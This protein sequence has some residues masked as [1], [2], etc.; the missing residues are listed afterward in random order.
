MI[1]IVGLL[2]PQ[3]KTSTGKKLSLHRQL[4]ERLSNA[5]LSGRLPSNTVLTPSRTFAVQLGVSRNTVVL[6]YEQLAAE[7]Y[8]IADQHGTRVAELRLH[9]SSLNQSAML[10]ETKLAERWNDDKAIIQ[11]QPRGTTGLLAP[12]VP[13]LK[14]F[15]L[16]KW[17]RTLERAVK[18]LHPFALVTKDPLGEFSLRQAIATHL[19]IARGVQCE[20]EQIVITEGAQ[21][22]LTLCARLLANPNDTVWVEDPCYSGAKSAFSDEQLSIIPIPVDNEGLAATT[23]HWFNQRPKL[24]FTS[25]A[26]QYPTGAVLSVARRLALIEAAKNVGTWIIE[27]D[28]D[29]DFRHTGTPISSMQGLAEHSPVIYIGSFSKTMF[30][31]IRIGFMVVPKTLVSQVTR[32]VPQI[33]QV[34]NQLQQIALAEFMTS[35]EFG[36]HLGRMRRIYRERQKILKTELTRY[37]P[38]DWVL[39]G[40][41]GMH[42]T[43]RLPSGVD[44]R[45]VAQ[46]ALSQGIS[47]DPLSSFYEQPTA[48]NCGLV[49]GYGNTPRARIPSAVGIL[50]EIIKRENDSWFGLSACAIDK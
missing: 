39:G 36:R 33:L 2:D 7:G 3:A 26:H 30:P 28:Y 13:S 37:F 42:L 1:D 48:N 34:S 38:D 12:G 9:K 4:V 17:K 27:D 20:A 29:G 14:D 18:L 8:I 45:S 15:P 24:I 6:A 46:Q 10:A 40:T 32:V 16:A 23:E 31:T 25:P 50:V 35:G 41:A 21:H 49:I 47:I 22:A 19:H 11:T 5:I 43:L 44:D